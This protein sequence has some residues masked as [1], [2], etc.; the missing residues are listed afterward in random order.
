MSETSPRLGLPLLMPAQAQKHV[1]HNEAL[2][3][4]ETLTQLVLEARDGLVPPP[5]PG[6]GEIHALGAAPQGAWDGQGGMLAA[7]DGTGWRFVAPQEGWRAWDKAAGRGCTWRSGAWADDLPETDHLDGVGIGTAHDATNR[8]AVA[9]QA[10]LFSHAGGGHQLKINKAGSADTA[11]LL[12]QSGWTG[13]AEMGLAGDTDFRIKVSADGSAWTEAAVFEAASG[14]MSGAAVQS[15]ATDAT[16][17]RLMTVGAFGLGRVTG[18]HAEIGNL[19]AMDTPAG[20]WAFTDTTAGTLPPGFA[21]FSGQVRVE[22]YNATITRQVASCNNGQGGIWWRTH[23]GTAWMGWRRLYDSQT[24]L[25]LVSQAGGVPTGA[26][27]ESGANANG[28]YLRLADGTQICWRIVAVNVATTE[29]QSWPFPVQFASGIRPAVAISHLLAAP[30]PVLGFGNFQGVTGFAVPGTWA[31]RLQTAG[32]PTG[33]ESDA[34]KL[35]ITATGRW[36]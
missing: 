8:L 2:L 22:R 28:S 29:Y 4:L 30:N 24:L 27:L 19:D 23:S 10:S 11:S 14:R 25:G 7:W 26:V 5:L 21:G 6:L 3:A 17:G 35:S 20:T 34:D 31:L 36:F 13:H 16:A 9:A 15:A 18:G 1:T 32:S 33:P 12:Y